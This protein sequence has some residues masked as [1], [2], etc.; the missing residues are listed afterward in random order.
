MYVCIVHLHTKIPEPKVCMH[1]Q[2]KNA[3][4]FHFFVD[5]MCLN[6]PRV[7][8]RGSG[9]LGSDCG[10]GYTQDTTWGIRQPKEK[11]STALVSSTWSEDCR[12]S[13]GMI[14]FCLVVA[15]RWRRVTWSKILDCPKSATL[16]TTSDPLMLRRMLMA[17]RLPCTI[18]TLWR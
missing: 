13:G 16:A 6:V 1:I 9:D 4:I 5:S 3:W 2:W 17:L 12:T 18:C 7:Y 15:I 11:T 14:S 8:G 10:S